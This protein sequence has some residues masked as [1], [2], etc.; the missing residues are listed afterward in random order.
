MISFKNRPGL[1]ASSTLLAT[2]LAAPFASGQSKTFTL[3]AEFTG[4]DT[5]STNVRTSQTALECKSA[6]DPAFCVARKDVVLLGRTYVS[7]ANTVWTDNSG[8]GYVVGI[9]TL[10]GKQ[11]TRLDSALEFING[12]ATGA[13]PVRNGQNLPGRI[14]TDANGDVW[15][16]NR[17]YNGGQ[18]SLSKFT[19][20]KSH[21]IDR[22]GDGQIQ[23]ASDLNG[24][25]FVDID[26]V[27]ASGQREFYGQNEECILTTIPIGAVNDVPRSVAVDKKGKIWVGTFSGRHIYR[28]NPN[29]PV[30]LELDI[31]LSKPGS[32]FPGN[33]Y[34]AATGKD[35]I[36]FAMRG[37]QTL[38]INI[39]TG[40][41]ETAPCG[42]EQYGVV[43]HPS[44]QYAWVG[45]W[46][47]SGYWFADF[48][49][50]PAKCSLIQ[51]PGLPVGQITAMTLDYD[52]NVWMS[53]YNTAKVY[54]SHFDK[55]NTD[56]DTT[57]KMGPIEGGYPAGPN[58]HGLSVD[59]RN[60]IWSV[61]DGAPYLAALKQD[62]A[63]LA[64]PGGQTLSITTSTNNIGN[65]Y[66]YLYSDFTGIQIDR[67][68]PFTRVGAWEGTY[69][70]GAIGIPWSRVIWNT[71]AL[72]TQAGAEPEGTKLVLSARA[73]DTQAGLATAAYVPVPNGKPDAG[74]VPGPDLT[75]LGLV[76][77]FI[78]V[79]ADLSGPGYE[80]S[81]LSDLTVQ[82]PCPGGAGDACCLQASDCNDGVTC[83]DDICP[84]PGS[85][86]QHPLKKD[87]CT[88]DTDCADT[89]TC[90]TD[91]CDL[92]KNS[93]VRTPVPGCCN[94][95]EDCDDGNLCT[96]D[97]CSGPGGACSFKA[98]Q[99]CCL[100]DNDCTKGNLC[101]N[102][103]CPAPGSL[104]KPSTKTD[105]CTTDADCKD[106]DSCTA[107]K[108]NVATKACSNDFVAGCCSFDAEC[109]DNDPCT[110]DK[111]VGAKCTY[112][113]KPG[114]A[115][116]T[117]QS[118]SLGDACDI[119]KAPNNFPPCK[120]GAKVC[121]ADGSFGCEGSVAP[122]EETCNGIDDDCDGVVDDSAKGC[123]AGFTCAGA[124]CAKPC[125]SGEFPCDPG[126]ACVAGFCLKS[127]GAG[128]AGGQA[129]AGGT[130]GKA[131]A[132]GAAG[133]STGGAAGQATGGAAGQATGGT[134]STGGSAGTGTAGS[135]GT[136]TAAGAAGVA[137]LGGAAGR[138]GTAG[139]TSGGGKAGTSGVGDT[140]EGN[141]YG[142]ATGGG[143][144][145]A[146][147]AVGTGAG[148]NAALLLGALG[149]VCALARRRRR[150]G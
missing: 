78:Q 105:C 86:C 77:R 15:I 13:F 39:N 11:V 37:G 95:S 92:A 136:G 24:D 59:F 65:P 31:D 62:G 36:F 94:S 143:L 48:S 53:G 91:T 80:T 90:T 35:Y 46:S 66:P 117:P 108:C 2:L 113:S 79:R 52:D 75:G 60:N 148:G 122:T 55:N 54:K 124:Q 38:R 131:G 99:G 96:A 137:G 141:A 109:N 70:G 63:P 125:K 72:G 43:A 4:A 71:E 146:T 126:L 47:G 144:R 32:V 101:S 135:A 98:I 68:A 14:T 111:C 6:D 58:P 107:D 127:G 140:D 25:G 102:A 12:K 22:N 89:N 115:C 104:C 114:D 50:S 112:E 57:K 17:C 97:L 16:V 30:T 134:S 9:D 119:P 7:Q 76:G 81:V 149:S 64:F 19:T 28:F 27:D 83:T 26:V 3:E 84:S 121:K 88:A 110:T 33:P 123:E 85:A 138:A 51:S 69:D 130:A 21:C 40:A 142:L 93:C 56:P 41:I 82:G 67:Q 23:T 133:Q 61:T 106:L 128:G 8:A 34:S 147:N 103:T 44:G 42:G 5:V 150:A 20:T 116:C 1:L 18:G 132:A 145:C 29:E 49:S 87:C 10:T 73:A 129:G 100:T 139:T 120:A 118:P 74:G 45:G